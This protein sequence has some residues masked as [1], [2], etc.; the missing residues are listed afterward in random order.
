[1]LA[2]ML[3]QAW[4]AS[5]LRIYGHMSIQWLQILCSNHKFH[6]LSIVLTPVKIRQHMLF[7][8]H[9][10][11]ALCALHWFIYQTTIMIHWTLNWRPDLTVKCEKTFPPGLSI[12]LL[13]DW[14]NFPAPLIS[15]YTPSGLEQCVTMSASTVLF[16]IRQ[17][18]NKISKGWGGNWGSRHADLHF[19]PRGG[20]VTQGSHSDCNDNTGWLILF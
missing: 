9:F 13:L 16:S 10:W 15:S 20:P 4:Q 19:Q 7:S 14:G 6:F 12:S 2:L 18:T 3:Q 5:G 8:K 17:I 11:V 1:M